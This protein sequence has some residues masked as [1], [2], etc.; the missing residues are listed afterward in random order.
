MGLALNNLADVKRD[1]G[2]ID[3][4]V[5]LYS[6]AYAIRLRRR[7]RL[8]GDTAMCEFFMGRVYAE[9]G[10]DARALLLHERARKTRE[11]VLHE[12]HPDLARSRTAVATLHMRLGDPD[13]AQPLLLKVLRRHEAVLGEQHW[14]PA[15][16]RRPYGE[17]PPPPGRP[18][19]AGPQLPAAPDAVPGRLLE[20][21]RISRREALDF[22]LPE[23]NIAASG[24]CN[25]RLSSE[26]CS[27]RA[28]GKDA[29]RMASVIMLRA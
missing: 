19:G 20:L 18:P 14:H 27:Y 9:Q 7:G 29:G 15:I 12:E 11:T 10:A 4:A 24:L 5:K 6:D 8:H 26:L 16:A 23:A 2:E 22:G 13:A 3:G 25:K 28:D 17:C 1:K 21:P